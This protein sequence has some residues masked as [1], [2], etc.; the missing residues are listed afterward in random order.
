MK[1]DLRAV[2]HSDLTAFFEHQRDAKAAVMAGFTPRSRAA[3]DDHWRRIIADP[4][5]VVM[6][7][8]VDD[9]V[10]GYVSAFP[11]ADR[12][13]IAYWFGRAYWNRGIVQAAV[14]QFLILHRRRPIFGTI[15][16]SNAASGAILRKCGF[17]PFGQ[18]TAPD[19]EPEEVFRLD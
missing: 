10:A 12:Q 15:V 19:G 5:T 13:E 18:D 3:F 8:E 6:T 14:A 4:Q 1:I 17:I 2:R 16:R 7:V 11:Q 9:A